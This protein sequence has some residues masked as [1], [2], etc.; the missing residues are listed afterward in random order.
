MVIWSKKCPESNHFH[1]KCNHC[2]GEWCEATFES[3]A[4]E[5]KEML[6]HVFDMCDNN[7]IGESDIVNFYRIRKI[8][9]VMEGT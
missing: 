4:S 2:K 9:E 1:H 3:E 6:E 7:A 8:E 5:M